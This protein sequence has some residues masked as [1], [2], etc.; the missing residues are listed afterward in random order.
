[1]DVYVLPSLTEGICNSLLEAM[2]TGLAVIA[3]ETGGNPEVVVHG[4]SGCL[5]PVGDYRQLAEQLL[6]FHG[7]PGLRKRLAEGA[8]RR[9][10]EEFSMESMIRGYANVYESLGRRGITTAVNVAA[11]V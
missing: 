6:L 10:R 1:M 9:V 2:S 3:T 4:E 8:V 11:R 7:N 5:F